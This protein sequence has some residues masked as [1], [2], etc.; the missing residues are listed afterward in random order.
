MSV[1]GAVGGVREEPTTKDVV[2]VGY[3][4]S[5][6]ARKAAEYA[7]EE[8]ALRKGEL[9]IVAVAPV[10]DY[11]AVTYGLNS[12]PPPSELI[13]RVRED[14]QKFA[15]E[16]VAANPEP[17]A[18]A[19][20]VVE[21]RTGVA[22][23]QLTEAAKGAALLVVGHRGRGA[24]ASAMMGSVG[25]QTVLHAQVPVTIVRAEVG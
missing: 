11:W 2:V 14:V 15:D 4:G 21:A 3:D 23:H 7:L 12:P 6:G 9:R 18:E 5:A 8:A 24:I 16:L 1:N 10:P 13:E 19:T 25:L 22:W 17:A 20:V